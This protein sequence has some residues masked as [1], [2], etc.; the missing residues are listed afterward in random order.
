VS[1]ALRADDDDRSDPA[2]TSAGPPPE[3]DAPTVCDICGSE[4]LA[5]IQCK[6]ICRNCRTILQTCSDL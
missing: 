4:D 1:A 2:Q 3:L 5:E 6:V